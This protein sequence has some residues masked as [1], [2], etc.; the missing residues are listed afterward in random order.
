MFRIKKIQMSTEVLQV[1]RVC[2]VLRCFSCVWLCESW[3]VAHQAPLSS[4]YSRQNIGLPWALL[5][6][7]FLIQGLNLGLWS[8]LHWQVSSLPLAPPGK[9]IYLQTWGVFKKFLADFWS[10]FRSAVLLF[11]HKRGLIHLKTVFLSGWREWEFIFHWC[12]PQK[13]KWH[14][15]TLK[16][17]CALLSLVECVWSRIQV[18]PIA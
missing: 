2:C 14:T 6:G 8:F 4:E 9:P 15:S 13:E 1:R 10:G 18:S 16:T 17:T 3:T 5:Q 12:A 11:S 7:I